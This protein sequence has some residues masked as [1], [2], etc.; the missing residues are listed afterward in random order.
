MSAAFAGAYGRPPSA[1]RRRPSAWVARLHLLAA[2]LITI[3]AAAA[4]KEAGVT[5]PFGFDLDGRQAFT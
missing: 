4:G 1:L 5:V 2:R 3:M